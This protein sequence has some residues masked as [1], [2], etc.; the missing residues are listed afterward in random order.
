M[1]TLPKPY[2]IAARCGFAPARSRK[3]EGADTALSLK[4]AFGARMLWSHTVL[5]TIGDPYNRP[6][7]NTWCVRF[8]NVVKTLA[9]W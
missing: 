5:V 4:F 1:S 7:P 6:V 8:R 3:W 2:V 9:P